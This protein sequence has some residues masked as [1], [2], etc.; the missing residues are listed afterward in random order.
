MNIKIRDLD[1]QMK[2]GNNGITL[3]VRSLDDQFLGKLR[4]GRAKLE[5][6]PGKTSIGRGHQMLFPDLIA[7]IEK[8]VARAA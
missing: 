7:L 2:L 8:S 3:E 1:V 5:W 4:I 6:C